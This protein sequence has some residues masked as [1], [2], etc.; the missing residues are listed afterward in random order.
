MEPGFFVRAY[1]RASTTEQTQAERSN[2]LSRRVAISR[3]KVLLW[4]IAAPDERQL[5]ADSVEKVGLLSVYS[6]RPAK[7]GWLESAPLKA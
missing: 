1:L 7:A 4:L 6:A 3:L 2:P 5:T